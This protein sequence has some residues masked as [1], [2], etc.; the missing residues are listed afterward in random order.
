VP[1]ADRTVVIVDDEPDVVL[2]CRVN[3]EFE[4]FRV[5]D[6]SDGDT[7]LALVQAELPDVVLLDVMLPESDGW[8]V[9]ERMKADP[10]TRDIPVVL[11]TAKVQDADRT[12]GWRAGAAE[13]VTKPFSPTD[14]SRI[15]ADVL[16]TTPEEEEQR[17]RR[18]LA[19]L[20]ELGSARRGSDAGGSDA[21]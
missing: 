8:T 13:Y 4:G 15:V 21:S 14:L 1:A 11:L 7:A 12:R 9:L 2:L 6:A 10:A 20:G 16:A 17:R 3:L 19:D 5:L 18:M